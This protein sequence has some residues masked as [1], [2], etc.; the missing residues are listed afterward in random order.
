[1]DDANVRKKYLMC[2]R[3]ACFAPT[4]EHKKTLGTLAERSG[5]YGVMWNA[6][7]DNIQKF[8]TI[9]DLYC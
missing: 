3:V 9:E 7:S 1:M 2:K 5:I 4:G 6:Y 8:I